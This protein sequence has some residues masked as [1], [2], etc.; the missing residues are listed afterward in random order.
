MRYFLSIMLVLVAFSPAFAD[1]LS[2]NQNSAEISDSQ[3]PYVAQVVLVVPRNYPLV[4]LE[5]TNEYY[6][7]RD[8]LGRE[9]WVGKNAVGSDRAVVV[10]VGIG[11]VR[12]GPG[13][14]YD[15]QMRAKQ[16]V[17]FQ[18]MEENDDWLHVKHESG[19][20][21]WVHKTITWGFEPR[22]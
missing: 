12:S 6:Q 16:G 9:G 14:G 17:A 13:A 18:V 22:T 4:I 19:R 2:V 5:A 10:K 20:Q 1:I 15:I 8:F 7:V 21:G 11:N 3:N